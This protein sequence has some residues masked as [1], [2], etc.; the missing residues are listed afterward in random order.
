VAAVA[1][2]GGA[3]FLWLGRE[4]SYGGI[5]CSKVRASADA[6]AKGELSANVQHQIRQHLSRCGPCRAFYQSL[7]LTAHARQ[8]SRLSV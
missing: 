7:G 8:S 6:Y 3:L 2:T 5:I 1:A 4:P